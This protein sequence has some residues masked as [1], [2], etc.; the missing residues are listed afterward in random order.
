LEEEIDFIRSVTTPIVEKHYPS[1]ANHEKISLYDLITFV[2]SI[3][4]FNIYQ[5]MRGA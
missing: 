2:V 5:M 1:K 3:L 4:S